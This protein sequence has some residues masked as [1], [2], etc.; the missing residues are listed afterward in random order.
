MLRSLKKT[1]REGTI[2]IRNG[3]SDKPPTAAELRQLIEEA[4][5]AMTTPISLRIPQADLDA[6]KCLAEKR[7]KG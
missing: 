6:A 1:S 3:A 2:R 4:R 7:G 5:A